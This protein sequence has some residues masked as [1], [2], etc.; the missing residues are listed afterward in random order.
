MNLRLLRNLGEIDLQGK[1]VFVRVDWNVPIEEGKVVDGFRIIESL[2]TLKFLAERQ[3]IIKVA[4]HLGD[5]EASVEPLVNFLAKH[6]IY[7]NLEVLPNLRSDPREEANDLGFAEELAEGC[8]LYINEA[9]SVC[10][11]EHSSIVTLPTLLPSYAGFRLEKEV[12]ELSVALSPE[13]PFLF[14]L[15]G[16]KFGTKLPLLEKYLQ[17][18]DQVFVG[19]ALANSLLKAKGVEV[20][21]SLVDNEVA[22]LNSI[23]NE[24]NLILPSDVVVGAD[25]VSKPAGSVAATEIIMDVGE[26][27]I[28]ELAQI[29]S[30][31][32]LIVW[33]GPMGNY[34]KGFTEATANLAKLVA[35][36]PARTIVGG[37]DTLAVINKLNLAGS[38]DF[39][40]TGGGAMLDFLTYGTLPGLTSLED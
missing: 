11:R 26:N 23:I 12:E 21:E 39:V 35:A 8:D 28:N 20:G 40:S 34:E 37:G 24:P 10:H 5:K 31:A 3:V 19:G 17:L 27:S 16:A 22:D 38:F 15:G 9:F 7:P 2:E 36:S 13:Y 32:K 25:K 6:F 29:I 1:T 4:T 33:N 14:I 30:E 18:A